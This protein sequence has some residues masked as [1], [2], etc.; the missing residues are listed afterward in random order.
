MRDSAIQFEVIIHRAS[1]AHNHFKQL[2]VTLFTE[3]WQREQVK[4]C[5]I[6]KDKHPSAAE[7]TKNEKLWK[8]IAALKDEKKSFILETYW[9]RQKLQNKIGFMKWFLS[10]QEHMK[11]VAHTIEN[12]HQDYDK[13]VDIMDAYQN[14][15]SEIDAFLDKGVDKYKFKEI[16]KKSPQKKKKLQPGDKSRTA[17]NASPSKQ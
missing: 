11:Q 1:V 14:L 9:Y 8:S 16:K 17:D 2:K 10:E 12:Y 15:L 6:L 13:Y 7:R 3:L 4:M 5:E